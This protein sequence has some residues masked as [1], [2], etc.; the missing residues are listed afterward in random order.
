MI[1]KIIFN[2]FLLGTLPASSY[3]QPAV[4]YD[5]LIRKLANDFETPGIAVAVMKNYEFKE[6]VFGY[7]NM[8]EKKPVTNKTAFNVASISKL[9]TAHAVMQ[10]AE[11]GKV[12]LDKP[13]ETYL[14]KWKF[15][16]SQYDTKQV[17]IRRVLNHSAGLSTEFGPG[18]IEKDTLLSLPEILS[19]KSPKRRSLRIVSKP[20]EEHVYSNL[21]YGL[22]Q[23]LVEEVSGKPFQEYIQENL[24]TKLSMT[25][26]SFKDPFQLDKSFG[27]ATPYD[28]RMNPLGQERFV[29]V[30]A[31]GLQTNLADLEKLMLEETKD[32]KLLNL[33]SLDQLHDTSLRS[34]YGLGHMI[35]Q[36]ENNKIIVGHTGLGMGWNASFQF[37]QG[38]GDGI[39]IL[40][41]GDN[42]SYIHN[43]LTCN[44][45]FSLT[46]QH[47]SSCNVA[48]DKKLNRISMFLEMA[49]EQGELKKQD[50]QKFMS[51][52][53][54][55]R[56]SLK[57]NN[58][59]KFIDQLQLLQSDLE[60]NIQNI[61]IQ[62][63]IKEVFDTCYD[64]MRQPWFLN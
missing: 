4:G 21:G 52:L 63:N 11:E 47:I 3:Q 9:V 58:F 18:F 57:N 29:V 44:W 60:S 17:T 31:A 64:W 55:S 36:K 12:D 56:K 23:L 34:K 5:S 32:K 35:S 39:I 20:G 50:F 15:A 10:L 59:K 33:S 28:Y 48:P 42:G 22:L 51:M 24:F 16:P 27:L 19:G 38:T 40:T 25:N 43:T 54:E 41:N 8:A 2:F 45:Y 46:R 61:T 37:I 53:E 62:K 26:S 49:T 7:A 13:I 14:T 1:K 30:A 6:F